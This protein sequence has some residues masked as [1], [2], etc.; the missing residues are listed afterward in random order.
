MQ[1]RPR[2]FRKTFV[3]DSGI[4]PYMSKAVFVEIDPDWQMLFVDDEVIKSGHRIGTAD[5]MQ[6]A[7]EHDVDDVES[8]HV[9][10]PEQIDEIGDHL[11]RL[12]KYLRDNGPSGVDWP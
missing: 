3:S 9:W 8:H 2:P 7:I 1:I 10:D 5:A 6:V 4:C 12:P 11:D